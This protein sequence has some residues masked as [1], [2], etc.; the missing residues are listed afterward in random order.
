M[1]KTI[2]LFSIFF[3]SHFV[4]ADDLNIGIPGII[5]SYCTY[6]IEPNANTIVANGYNFNP[7]D[8]VIIENKGTVI[9]ETFVAIRLPQDSKIVYL[10]KNHVF[11]SKDE[12][13]AVN[14]LDQAKAKMYKE[15]L[16][17]WEIIP[18]K[19]IIKSEK[20]IYDNLLKIKYLK[21]SELEQ[22]TGYKSFKS[23]KQK[24]FSN[25]YIDVTYKYADKVILVHKLGKKNLIGNITLIKGNI[26]NDIYIL[27]KRKDLDNVLGIP[28]GYSTLFSEIESDFYHIK[29]MTKDFIITFYFTE[30]A[31]PA[32]TGDYL[33]WKS[34]LLIS[35]EIENKKNADE[36]P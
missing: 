2:C 4:F 11:F 7:L 26:T 20:I 35:I 18:E 3:L 21:Y 34:F 12:T 5:T 27:M 1:K 36:M 17:L 33:D 10:N 14:L 30:S 9:N 8:V 6:F 31:K 19:E 24:K 15:Q 32:N 13:N 22:V 29:Y 28:N 25:Y 16:D 23:A